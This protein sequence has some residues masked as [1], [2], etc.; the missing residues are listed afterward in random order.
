MPII[1]VHGVNTRKSPSYTAGL[2]VK[3]AFFK[4]HLKGV[5]INGKTLDQ[6]EDIAFP[7]WGDLAT[8]FA[9]DMASLPRGEMQALGGAAEPT[10]RAVLA[11]I[12]DALPGD[13]TEEP[14]TALA[15]HDLERAVEMLAALALEDAPAGLEAEVA[16]FAV[17]IQAYAEAEPRPPW[18]AG[19]TTD[20]QLVGNLNLAV[21]QHDAI[22][23][24]GLGDVFNA[25]G[26]AAV[27]LKNA[28][29]GLAGKAINKSGD[30]ASTK[31]LG[32]TREPL[33]ANLGRFFGD[34]F[35]YFDSRGDK[36][37]PGQ[38]PQ[39]I[40][41]SFDK[42]AA[43]VDADEPLVIV[44][45]SLGGVIS[46]DLLGHYRPDL[47]VDL[48]VSV[49]SQIA[50]FEEIKLF[51]TSD[52]DIKLGSKAPTPANIKNWINVYDE[53]DIF[54]YACAKVFDRVTI[55]AMYDTKTYVVKSHS[56]YFKQA[57]LYK[58]LR[59]RIDELA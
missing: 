30:F 4:Q 50:H 8:T 31:L 22:Q 55:D 20:A 11:A 28:A 54:S 46:F 48:F 17:A 5:E 40:L 39:R 16:E 56:A 37:E 32:W 34:V 52:K 15:Q 49:G 42:A 58:R 18:L 9:W 3:R 23:A 14:L 38:I 51:H 44:G 21:K 13:V 43:A 33:N 35:I 7:Y 59:A 27:K 45:H 24:Q 29:K 36:D 26:T 25:I 19:V 6:V 2:E 53:V 12:K 1:F 57:R 10:L 41:A 47:E